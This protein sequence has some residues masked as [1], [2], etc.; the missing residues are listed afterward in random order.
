[1][2]MKSIPNKNWRKKINKR[3][4]KKRLVNERSRPGFQGSGLGS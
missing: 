1:M 2:E 4:R 3:R